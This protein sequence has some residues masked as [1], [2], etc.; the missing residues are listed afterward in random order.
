MKNVLFYKEQGLEFIKG[1]H[2]S[3]E[4]GDPNH[5]DSYF[6]GSCDAEYINGGDKIYLHRVVKEFAWRKNTGE[7]PKYEG[8]ITVT[9]ENG[10]IT[11]GPTA[12]FFDWSL[13]IRAD[14]IVGG[15]TIETW[16]PVLVKEEQSDNPEP[17]AWNNICAFMREHKDKIGALGGNPEALIKGLIAKEY[18]IDMRTEKEKVVD[19]ARKILI[20]SGLK[21]NQ[22]RL[23]SLYDAGMLRMPEGE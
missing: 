11:S 21:P 18:D 4:E 6:S 10:N 9:F 23:N 14:D 15:R 1:D 7:V 19:S 5:G 20:K 12:G 2:L 8:A 3:Y 16:R 22:D 13:G 17:N